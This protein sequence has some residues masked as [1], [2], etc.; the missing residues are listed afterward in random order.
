M[1][2]IFRGF[3]IPLLALSLGVQGGALAGVVGTEAMLAESAPESEAR[4]RVD[5]EL[6]RDE[7]RSQMAAMGVEPAAVEARLAAL[8]E[9]ELAELAD[10]IESAPAGGSV[11]GVVGAVFVVLLILE[12]VGVTDVFKAI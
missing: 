9:R 1:Q 8:S 7:V 3:V 6:A 4:A 12:A 11:L 5:A 2:N 10:S